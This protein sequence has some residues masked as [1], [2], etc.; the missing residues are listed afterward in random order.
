[1]YAQL[2]KP[3]AF[4]HHTGW[5]EWATY[6]R[7]HTEVEFDVFAFPVSNRGGGSGSGNSGFPVAYLRFTRGLFG[8]FVSLSLLL[9]YRLSTM[10]RMCFPQKNGCGTVGIV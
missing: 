9:S 1:M 10:F 8:E 2:M 3:I 5:A 4:V 7:T 6:V